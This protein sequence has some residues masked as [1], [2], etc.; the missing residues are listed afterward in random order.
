M[1][2]LD[3]AQD[4]QTL[5]EINVTPF[6]DVLLVLL[7]V[8]MLLAALS[9]PPGFQKRLA[10]EHAKPLPPPSVTDL[11]FILVEV[12]ATGRIAIDGTPIATT[13]LYD[14]MAQAV[15]TARRRGGSRHIAVNADAQAS[16]DTIIKILDAAR[17]AGD[18]DVGFVTR[19]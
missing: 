2:R 16:Y 6:T 14:V 8:F 17:H 5:H 7:I 10:P 19:S 13:R 3:L 11:G 9:V 1:T 4:S 12:T 15:A 18:E